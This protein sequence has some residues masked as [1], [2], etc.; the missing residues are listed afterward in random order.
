MG[1]YAIM[2]DRKVIQLIR[3]YIFDFGNVLARFDPDALTAPYAPDSQERR[4][5]QEVVFDRLY[6]DP[7]DSG[8]IT[9]EQVREGIRSRLPADL[10][11]K[12]CQAYDHWIEN[13]TPIAGMQELA[14]E[15]K[16]QGGHLFLLSDISIG[17]AEGYQVNPW[18]KELFSMFDG[19][20]CS[21]PIGMT[22]PHKETFQYLLE[23]FGLNAGECVF[24]DDRQ[25]NADG[26][27]EAGIRAIVFNGDAE[28]LRHQ[29]QNF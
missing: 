13:L 26:A 2:S 22:K 15:I 7:L 29:L 11:E 10:A 14:A 12:G 21:G 17:F 28:A 4:M 18:V 27:R 6:W 25:V 19:L 20:V 9:D 5:I 24:I 16:A 1:K 3:N 8:K 23:H